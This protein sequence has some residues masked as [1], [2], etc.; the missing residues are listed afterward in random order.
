MSDHLPIFVIAGELPDSAIAT[1]VL[2]LRRERHAP[3]TITAEDVTNWIDDAGTCRRVNDFAVSLPADLHQVTN[4]LA[5]VLEGMGGEIAARRLINLIAHAPTPTPPT[6][7]EAKQPA[8]A[9]DLINEAR[10]LLTAR[11]EQRDKPSG[12]RSMKATV[13]AFNALFGTALTETQGW[14]FMEL[15]KISRSTGGRVVR[16]DYVDG[17]AYAALAGEAALA[18]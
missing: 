6:T 2:E 4:A 9:A 5:D 16:D 10:R 11:G 14:Q 1:Q 3:I 17:S 18:E 13:N 8:R 12:E 7:T 15:L